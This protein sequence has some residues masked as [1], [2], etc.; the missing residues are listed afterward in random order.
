MQPLRVYLSST[1]EDLK[2]HRDAVGLALARSGLTVARMETYVASDQRPLDLCLKDVAQCD[3]FVGLYAWRYG[4][5]PPAA[6]GNP[7]ACSITHLEYLHAETCGLRKLLFFAHP[8]TRDEWPAAFRDDLTGQGDGGAKLARFRQTVGTEKT[9]SFFRSQDELATLVLASI[10]RSGLSGRVYNVPP[11]PPGLAAR[12][13][14][15]DAVVAGLVGAGQR[16]GRN[17]LVQG[18]GGFGKTTLAL[19]ACHRPEVVQ[20][21]PDGLLWVPLGETPDLAHVLGDLHVLVTGSPVAVVGLDAMAGALAKA[22]QGRQCLLVIDD[23]WREEDLAP[24]LRLSGPRLLLT[25]RH[26]ALIQQAAQEPWPEV[27]VDEMSAD[28]AGAMLGRGLV[29]DAAA[30]AALRDLAQRLGCWPLLLDL[31]A[32]RLREEHKRGR[33]SL[34]Q[35]L[36]FVA[37]LFEKKGVLGFDR[38]DSQARNAAVARSVDVGLE[39]VDQMAPGANLPARAAELSIFPENMA[40]PLQVLGELWGL[41]AFDLEDEVMR[42]LDQISLL[43]WD[44]QAGTVGLHMMIHRVLDARLQ[45]QPG[46]AAVVHRRLLAAWGDPLHLPHA[47]AWRWLGWHCLQAGDGATLRGLLLDLDWLQ[48]RLRAAV[49]TKDGQPSTDMQAVLHDH[50]L[51]P[52]DE[53]VVEVGRA[54]RASEVLRMDPALLCQQLHGRLDGSRLA[55]SQALAR[56]A[57]DEIRRS[58]ALV[59]AWAALEPP[60]AVLDIWR[61]LHDTATGDPLLLPD[62][63]RLL[64]SGAGDKSML[65]DVTDDFHLLREVQLPGT[66]RQ[67]LLLPDTRHVLYLCGDVE[68][69]GAIEAWRWNLNQGGEPQWVARWDT[70]SDWTFNAAPG[71]RRALIAAPEIGLITLVDL[72]RDCSTMALSADFGVEKGVFHI[73]FGPAGRRAMLYGH[74]LASVQCIDLAEGGPAVRPAR[75]PQPHWPPGWTLNA[76]V[77]DVVFAGD[78]AAAAL[79]LLDPDDVLLW[80]P[81][82]AAVELVAAGRVGWALP[83]PDG[84]HALSCAHGGSTDTYAAWVLS[85]RPHDRQLL[86]EDLPQRVVDLEAWPE[87]RIVSPDGRRLLLVSEATA[88]VLGWSESGQPV[89]EA[90]RRPGVWRGGAAW[91]PDARRVLLWAWERRTLWCWDMAQHPEPT[92]LNGLASG[93]SGALPLGD[94]QRVVTWSAEGSLQLWNLG[95]P[96][97]TWPRACH[98]GAVLGAAAVGDG[99]A[100][101]TWSADGSSRLWDVETGQE[102]LQLR[103]DAPDAIASAVL[104]QDGRQALLCTHGVHI[105]QADLSTGQMQPL[106]NAAPIGDS[107]SWHC[108]R[109]DDHWVILSHLNDGSDGMECP[110]HLM[111]GGQAALMWGDAS[112]YQRLLHL[113]PDGNAEMVEQDAA[114][115]CLHLPLDDHRVLVL[116]MGAVQADEELVALEHAGWVQGLAGSA[117]EAMLVRFEPWRGEPGSHRNGMLVVPGESWALSWGGA[118]LLLAWRLDRPGPPVPLVGHDGK[119]LGAQALPDGRR[120]LSWSDDGTLRLWALDSG[121]EVTVLRSDWAVNQAV[122]LPCGRRVVSAGW[123]MVCLWDLDTARLLATHCLDAEVTALT[124]LPDGARVFVGDKGGRV[125]VLHIQPRG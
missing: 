20:A 38:R 66:V 119:V 4:Y 2:N 118:G 39:L 42:P 43:R 112:G 5:E 101:L 55:P 62:G 74:D 17:T 25:T 82:E 48:A 122:V 12:T 88:T 53:A 71:N 10:L 18:A 33:G 24:F 32:A 79:C 91:M 81:G 41:D 58:E 36:A 6:H 87:Q 80:H 92:A 69:G 117:E 35:C 113:G 13:H 76:S 104:L 34:A 8:D 95:V 93:I 115:D 16:P 49:R 59:P 40:I 54:L 21:Y 23:V 3:V 30:E 60:A 63:R 77:E 22:L 1:F 19:M 86:P 47:H 64:V 7:D 83:M 28:E 120:V 121:R 116:T 14:L 46:G 110:G 50:A 73:A 85:C 106:A 29:L 123:Q 72:E 90:Q 94:G 109:I 75:R 111:A 44:R 108:T 124:L 89:V 103:V 45:A 84:H 78:D 105:Q 61:H 65:L 114:L 97:V 26:R 9:V 125:Q 15:V 102:R 99:R 68:E 96:Q 37:T 51:L 11:L 107:H 70:S 98:D 67:V 100:V 52:A 31:A 56:A 57:L 27:P